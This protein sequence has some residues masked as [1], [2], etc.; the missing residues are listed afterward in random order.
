MHTK[1][2]KPIP[3]KKKQRGKLW[4]KGRPEKKAW[5]NVY[6]HSLKKEKKK[7]E[8]IYRIKNVKFI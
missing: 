8:V 5:L 1:K 6:I 2:E 3:I 7:E 4:D